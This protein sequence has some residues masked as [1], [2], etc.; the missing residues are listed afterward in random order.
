MIT[1]R[2]QPSRTLA[3]EASW[4]LPQVDLR[5]WACRVTAIVFCLACLL[6][7]TATRIQTTKLRYQLNHLHERQ[8]ALQADMD[9][10]KVEFDSLSRPQRIAREAKILGLVTPGTGQMIRLDE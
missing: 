2:T 7:L 10:L 3:L 1:E 8:L 5:G 4:A 6:F 9:R